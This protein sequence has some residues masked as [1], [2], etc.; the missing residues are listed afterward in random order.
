LQELTLEEQRQLGVE[1]LAK[2]N[3]RQLEE[4]ESAMKFMGKHGN[5]DDFQDLMNPSACQLDD[6]ELEAQ[7]YNVLFVLQ[8]NVTP[9]HVSHAT[10][11]VELCITTGSATGGR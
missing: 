11:S 3:K 2:L 9:L 6:K 4:M 5:E 10:T 1:K 7:R 8:C